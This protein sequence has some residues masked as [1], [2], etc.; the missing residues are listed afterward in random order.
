M[1]VKHIDAPME[2]VE[3]LANKSEHGHASNM[4]L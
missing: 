4:L 3:A 1:L 2:L